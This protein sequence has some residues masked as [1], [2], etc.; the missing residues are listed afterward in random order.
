MAAGQAGLPT[1]DDHWVVAV[2]GRWGAGSPFKEEL[3]MLVLT[4]APSESIVIRD[5]IVVRVIDVR[6]STVRLAIEAPKQVTVHRSEVHKRI[7]EAQQAH[8][9]DQR[10]AGS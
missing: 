10:Q 6:G 3:A 8:R 5:D 2:E 9:H 1:G 4:R 7:N